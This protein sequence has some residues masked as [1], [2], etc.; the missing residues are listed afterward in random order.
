MVPV[1]LLWVKPLAA[2]D[3]R[4]FGPCCRSLSRFHCHAGVFQELTPEYL[5]FYGC[6][7]TRAIYDSRTERINI[8]ELALTTQYKSWLVVTTPL[9]KTLHGR[10]VDGAGQFCVQSWAGCRAMETVVIC[11]SLHPSSEGSWA[12]GCVN[13]Q[14]TPGLSHPSRD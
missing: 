3:P 6:W 14:E 13:G 9:R 7:L 1:Y 12:M 8:H 10:C 5:C 4:G 11:V 2:S